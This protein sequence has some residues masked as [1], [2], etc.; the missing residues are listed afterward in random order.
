MSY[1]LQ[2]VVLFISFS[3]FKQGIIIY[4]RIPLY[5]IWEYLEVKDIQIM[6]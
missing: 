2:Y 5:N 4:L 3:V 6:I 1:S